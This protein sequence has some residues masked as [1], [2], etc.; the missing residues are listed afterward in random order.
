MLVPFVPGRTRLVD[1]S[2]LLL[3]RQGV[4]RDVLFHRR[5]E[6]KEVRENRGNLVLF[7]FLVLGAG[8]TATLGRRVARS[9]SGNQGKSGRRKKVRKKVTSHF[10]RLHQ[11]E[12]TRGSDRRLVEVLLAV[13]PGPGL[14]FFRDLAWEGIL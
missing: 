2:R 6:V 7:R 4:T 9:V 11:P 14:C 5:G 1:L 3:H 8:L 13:L 12:E 10:G